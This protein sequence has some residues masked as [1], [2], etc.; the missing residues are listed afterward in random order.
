[1]SLLVDGATALGISLSPGQ[2]AQFDQLGAALR[3]ANRRAN[4]TAITDADD[5]EVNLFLDSVT[6]AMPLLHVLRSGEAMR[7]VDIG[8]GAGFPGLP[9]KLVFP[10][11]HVTLIESV[12]KKAAYLKDV[13]RMLGLTDVEV[14]AE[15]AETCG[16]QDGY[17][18]TFDWA[19][20]RAVGSLSV[21][22]ELCAPF[23]APGGYLVS[24]RRGDLEA[25]TL[26]AAPA[27]KA[28]KLWAQAPRVID[29]PGLADGR[30][31]VVAEKYAST[32]ARY[33]RRPGI[34]AKRPL[35]Q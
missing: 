25:E 3:E 18:D 31:L 12:G 17:R 10:A 15:R 11:L 9:L 32:P 22:I 13:V 33:P 27:F 5:V 8:S 35:V 23:L 14:L 30:G 4:L 7:L 20:A 34:P 16:R 29:L 19:T 1:M 26:A 24:Q 6:A 28:L 2:T 21:V